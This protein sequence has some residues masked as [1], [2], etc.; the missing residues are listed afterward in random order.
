LTVTGAPMISLKKPEGS[1]ASLTDVGAAAA[2]APLLMG[3]ALMVVLCP[4]LS[5]SFLGVCLEWKFF[6]E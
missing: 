1:R 4:A 2:A 3:D 5:V 6:V